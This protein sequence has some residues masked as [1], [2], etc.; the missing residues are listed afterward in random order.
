MGYFEKGRWVEL[1]E[2][3]L[4]SNLTE[5]ITHL[6]RGLQNAAD[7]MNEWNKHTGIFE[8]GKEIPFTRVVGRVIETFA[9]SLQNGIIKGLIN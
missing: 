2:D 8:K 1:P 7:S 3:K 6:Q 4:A 5:A 9:N